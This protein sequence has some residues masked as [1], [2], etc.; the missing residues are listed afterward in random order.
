MDVATIHDFLCN[1]SYWAKGRPLQTVQ[2]SIENSVC[3]GA[4]D[5]SG[6]TVG[7]GRVITDRT[8]FAYIADVFVLEEHRGEGVGQL[9]IEHMMQHPKLQVEH[10]MLIT[11][12]AHGLYRKFGFEI[13]ESINEY[14][15]MRRCLPE[16]EA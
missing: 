4:Y 13:P 3:F 1:Q 12:D 15:S 10:W 16:K 14:M 11:A 6:N 5:N 9:L 8:T 7:F 2:K